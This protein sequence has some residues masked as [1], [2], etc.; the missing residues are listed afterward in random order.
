M[1]FCHLASFIKSCYLTVNYDMYQMSCAHFGQFSWTTEIDSS[2]FHSH[3]DS[4]VS[5]FIQSCGILR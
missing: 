4:K 5:T 1:K 3:V 2:I